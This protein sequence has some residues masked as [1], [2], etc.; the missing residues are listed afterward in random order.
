MIL[1]DVA[2]G[3]EIFVDSNIF[4]YHFTGRSQSC[5]RLLER[6]ESGEVLGVTG[7]HV[8]LEALHRLMM[9]EAVQKGLVSSGN[10]VRRLKERPDIVM[11]LTD[12]TVQAGQIPHMGIEVLPIDTR[13]IRPSQDVR[14]RTGLMVNDSISVALM[15]QRGITSIASQDKDFLNVAGFQVYSADDF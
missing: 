9:L 15:V 6:C 7:T 11:A 5:R 8:I 4:I 13:L 14:T 1:D 2:S 12:Y 10:V 3:Q